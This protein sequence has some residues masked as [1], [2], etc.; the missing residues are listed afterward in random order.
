M[1]GCR[2]PGGF[3]EPDNVEATINVNVL[4]RDCGSQIAQQINGRL[5][6]FISL[7]VAL[8]RSLSLHVLKHLVNSADGHGA[9]S[10]N[11]AGRD[12]VHAN[13]LLSQFKRQVPSR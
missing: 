12:G 4:A 2:N 10:A 9:E 6:N 5:S 7:S 11:R 8:Q 13:T 3:S 1:T